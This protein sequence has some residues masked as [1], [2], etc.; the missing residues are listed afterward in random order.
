MPAA[1]VIPAPTYRPCPSKVFSITIGTV[2]PK[3]RQL[4]TVIIDTLVIAEVTWI[5]YAKSTTSLIMTVYVQSRIKE[6]SFN[7]TQLVCH[8]N[9]RLTAMLV[10]YLRRTSS[11]NARGYFTSQIQIMGLHGAGSMENAMK[12]CLMCRRSV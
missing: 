7:S 9:E 5:S 4:T 12:E 3:W 6:N 8:H 11:F 10:L 1:A 2:L